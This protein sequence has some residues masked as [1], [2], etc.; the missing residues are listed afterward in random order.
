MLARAASIAAARFPS[1]SVSSAQAGPHDLAEVFQMLGASM[2]FERN[3][4]IYGEGESADYFYH[5]ET[6]AVRT[7]KLLSD[8]RRQIGAF[9]LPGDFLGLEAGAEHAFSAEAIGNCTVRYAKR[10]SILTMS[11]RDGVLSAEL[12]AAT[13]KSLRGAQEHMLL[14][15]RKTAE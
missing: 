11:A 2:T 14:L 13:A 6:G 9:Y 3:E 5:V 12:W 10:S 8:G 4:E 7:Y 15:G 1:K